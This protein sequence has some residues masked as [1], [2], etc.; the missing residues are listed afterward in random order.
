MVVTTYYWSC[1]FQRKTRK[2]ILIRKSIQH[3]RRNCIWVKLTTHFCKVFF[4]SGAAKY[5]P[6]KPY[7]EEAPNTTDVEA[8][9]KRIR[10][11]DPSLKELNLN[12]I[13]V[14]FHALTG[15]GWQRIAMWVRSACVR[16][17]RL[18]CATPPLF[19]SSSWQ[20]VDPHRVDSFVTWG[21]LKK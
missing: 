6:C 15:L 9:L 19:L 17:N 7:T 11:N 13:K 8:S 16:R 12:N 10:N 14:S 5:E 3:F 2:F 1:V 4:V 20:V 18:C 21:Q